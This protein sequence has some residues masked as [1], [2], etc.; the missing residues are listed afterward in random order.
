MW[1]ELCGEPKWLPLI[2]GYP[3][4]MHIC[5]M[6]WDTQ[7]GPVLKRHGT[8]C[9]VESFFCQPLTLD[10]AVSH[11]F[12]PF[13]NLQ[14]RV[15]H[16]QSFNCD[17]GKDKLSRLSS[18]LSFIRLQCERFGAANRREISTI[19]SL[20]TSGSW[21]HESKCLKLLETLWGSYHKFVVRS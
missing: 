11:P 5:L 15:H 4:I 2:S 17:Q 12:L 13:R 9:L 18:C 8:F 14:C 19:Q 6:A 16:F 1:L 21:Q 3:D 10:C 7:S 20:W